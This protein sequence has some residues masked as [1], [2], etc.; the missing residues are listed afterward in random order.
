MSFR[1]VEFCNQN[2][3]FKK[4]FVSLFTNKTNL[5]NIEFTGYSETGYGKPDITITFSDESIFYIEVKTRV[6]TGFQENQVGSGTG[7]SKLIKDHGQSIED[8]FAYLLDNNHNID[9]C[10]VDK[11]IYW[12]EVLNLVRDFN[13]A[14]LVKDIIQ[15]V[16]GISSEEK[17][18]GAYEELFSNPYQLAIFNNQILRR[19]SRKRAR[20]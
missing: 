1:L 11:I 2:D 14:E 7:Y 19:E 5:K 9:E 6:L 8:S 3:T 17:L 20:N 18:F 12:Q 10:L 15:N 13:N 4:N 16:D